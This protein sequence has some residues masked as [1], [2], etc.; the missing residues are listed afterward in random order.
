MRILKY[1]ILLILLSIVAFIVYI[2]TQN[3]NYTIEKSR[4]IALD[5]SVLFNYVNDYRNWEEFGAWKS[6]DPNIK[7][8][9]PSQ[10]V[11]IEGS[12]FWD[13]SLGKGSTTTIF[14]T[15]NDSI[16]Q[17]S[18]IGDKSYNSFWTFKKQ[19]DG[20]KVTWSSQGELGFWSKFKAVLSGGV[21]K[22]IAKLHEKTLENLDKILSHEINTFNIQISGIV[23]VIGKMYLQQKSNKKI[24]EHQ[25]KINSIIPALLSF[26]Q[27]NKI[28]TSGSPFVIYETYDLKKDSTKMAVGIPITEEIFT[29]PES[30]F[31][32]GKF[33]TYN[34]VKT[35]LKGD[36]S[37]AKKA[38]DKAFAY[39]EENKLESDPNGKYMAVF[40]K[41]N[42][43]TKK[44]SEWITD[45]YIP[46]KSKEHPTGGTSDNVVE[47]KP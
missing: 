20:T 21:D 10:T 44:P 8:T 11:G 45:I 40:I 19:D 9:Y 28:K 14:I 18:T 26:V 12:Y 37:H 24:S 33:D 43:D 42:T 27:Q 3:G 36:Y 1:V 7:F 6:L 30:Q 31:T 13:G 22:N 46:V 29:T 16:A 15:E 34:A 32:F 25:N 17:R 38:W 35:T 5:K 4:I 39:M 23:P 41:N 2:S 47:S